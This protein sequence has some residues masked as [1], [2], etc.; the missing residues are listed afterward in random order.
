MKFL[1]PVEK[2][3]QAP[4]RDIPWTPSAVVDCVGHR[5]IIHYDAKFVNTESLR[6][7]I[8]EASYHITHLRL[9]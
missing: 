4:V 7:H 5:F 2:S 1:V 3:Y 8:G 6:I 9:Q